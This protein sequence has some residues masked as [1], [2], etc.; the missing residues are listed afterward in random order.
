MAE[1]GLG[2]I[3]NQS[4]TDEARNLAQCRHFGLHWPIIAITKPDGSDRGHLV[5]RSGEGRRMVCVEDSN[6]LPYVRQ[7]LAGSQEP[8]LCLRDVRM[9]M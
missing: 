5:P 1:I 4:A 2:L 3:D 7:R 6:Y 9:L 8:P